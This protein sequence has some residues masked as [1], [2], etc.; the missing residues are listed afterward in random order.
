MQPI[1]TIRGRVGV[2]SYTC[3]CSLWFLL[4]VVVQVVICVCLSGW[5]SGWLSDCLW[6]QVWFVTLLVMIGR[7]RRMSSLC[8]S[9][10]GARGG[11]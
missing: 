11:S 2:G 5:L 4:V 9:D 3:A 10:C 1:H 7:N 8:L 6:C